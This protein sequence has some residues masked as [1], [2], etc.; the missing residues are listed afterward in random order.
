MRFTMICIGS[1]G[2]V[3]PYVLLGSELTRRGHDVGICAFSEFE[4]LVRHNGMRFFPLSGDAR[5]FMSNIMKPSARGVGY[6]KQVLDSLRHIIDPFLADLQNACAD[7]EVIVAT[8][9][10]NIIQSIAAQRDVPFIQ[11][12][13]YP[14][15]PNN[16]TPISAAPGLRAGR[17]WNLATYRLAYLIISTLEVYYLTGWRKAQGMPPRRLESSPS[18]LLNGHTVPVLYAMSPLLMPRPR[19]WGESIHMTGFWLDEQESEYQPSPELAAFLAQTPK[20]VYIGFGS[21]TSGD[22]GATLNIVLEAIRLSGV[23]AVL[24]TGWGNVEGIRQKDVYVVEGYVPHDWLFAHVSAVVH[25]GGAGTT[26]AGLCAGCPTLA[27]PFGGDQPFWAL[28]VRMMGLGPRPIRRDKLTAAKLARALRNLTTVG[29]YR[30]AARELG[31]RL[32]TENGVR[33]A[34]DL[35]EREVERWLTEDVTP[36]PPYPHRRPKPPYG[37]A[38]RVRGM[39]EARHHKGKRR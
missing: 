27:I 22:M 7:A 15:D 10:G 28:R 2:D 4:Q 9:F 13:Y 33:C 8:Y 29:S 35:I 5:E 39:Q 11:T 3:R 30:V 25:H 24:S 21:M 18:S 31:E 36:D 6:L 20:P 16:T 38:R 12:H 14:M 23:R 1:T 19:S 17:A 37:S 34:A 26:A 32:R